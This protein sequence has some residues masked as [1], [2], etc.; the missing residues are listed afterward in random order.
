[1]AGASREEIFD[2]SA[3]AYYRALL[4][5]EHYP[6]LLSEVSSIDILENNEK[7]AKIRYNIS[8]AMKSIS[9]TLNMTHTPNKRLEWDLDSGNLFKKNHGCWT[10]EAVG[11]DKCK[12]TYELEIG[13]KIFAPKA[14]TNKLVAVNLPRMM[15]AFYEH[16]LQLEA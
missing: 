7:S 12:V 10:L 8:I 16:A 5:Y 2:I 9:Y 11:K 13:L 14:I 1:M 3:E 4:D 6:E 15:R